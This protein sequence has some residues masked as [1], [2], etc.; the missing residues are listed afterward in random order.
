MCC[1]SP[2]VSCLSSHDVRNA[3]GHFWMCNTPTASSRIPLRPALVR[4][5]RF[6]AQFAHRYRASR[7]CFRV[8]V[9]LDRGAALCRREGDLF[10]GG[11]NS[12]TSH[13]VSTIWCSLQHPTLLYHRHHREESKGTNGLYGRSGVVRPVANLMRLNFR[14]SSSNL[15]FWCEISRTASAS[16][17]ADEHTVKIAHWWARSKNPGAWR[18]KNADEIWKH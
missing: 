1:C 14:F 7:D 16:T 3:C 11:L 4:F 2:N 13:Q 18:K 8:Q 17:H 6:G 12:R 10:F 5:Q 9:N 15:D